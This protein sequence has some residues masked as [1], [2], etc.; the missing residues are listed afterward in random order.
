MTRITWQEAATYL[1]D[2][3]HHEPSD[4]EINIYLDFMHSE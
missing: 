2:H 1:R 3:L 4:D